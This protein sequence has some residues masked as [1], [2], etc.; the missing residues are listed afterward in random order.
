MAFTSV[1]FKN[2]ATGAVRKAPVGFSWT[3]LFFWFLPPLLRRD[4]KWTLVIL[5]LALLTFGI[6]NILFIFI[7]NQLYIG[8]LIVA[9]YKVQSIADGDLT[10]VREKLGTDVPMLEAA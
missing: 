4:W 8:E 6:S 9:G 2:P 7:Y 5:S 10:S 3:V 1:V